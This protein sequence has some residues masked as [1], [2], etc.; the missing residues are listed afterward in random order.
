[1][2]ALP[3]QT[4]SEDSQPAVDLARGVASA[5]AV[6]A[7]RSLYILA[8]EEAVDPLAVL[9]GGSVAGVRGTWQE[10]SGIADVA[11]GG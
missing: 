9:A 1:M 7:G 8:Q 11:V 6:K 5:W 2:A 3:F 4:L 10:F